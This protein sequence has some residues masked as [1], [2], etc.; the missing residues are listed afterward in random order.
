MKCFE[1]QAPNEDDPIIPVTA[2][3]RTKIKSDGTI[4]KLKARV[5]LRGDQ[6]AEMMDFETWCPVGNFRGLRIFLCFAA[7]LKCR[8]YQLDFV[9]AFLQAKAKNRVFTILPAEWKEF[10]PDLAEWFGTPLRL[11]KSIYGSTDSMRNWDDTLA[12]FL[13][14]DFGFQRCPSDGSIYIYK[15]GKSFLYLINAVDDELYFTN[16]E[17]LKAEFE[18]RITEKFDV[19]LMGQAHWYLQARLT[20]HANYSITLDQSRYMALIASRFLPQHPTTNITTEDKEKY[21]SPLPTTFV[22]SKEDCSKDSI[23]VKELEQKYGFQY[24]SA[25]GMLIFPT[26]HH[27]DSTVCHPKISKVQCT[28]WKAALQSSHPSYASCP[29]SQN[30]IW[31]T[32]PCPRSHTT[33]SSHC[34]TM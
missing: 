29:N 3:F 32:I 26:Q 10:Y 20:Q 34:E 23:E 4:E 19:K 11:L 9:G 30:R 22:P 28:T 31:L 21:R 17:Q 1:K 24:S 25:V 7:R 2:K 18:K 15:K 12:D 16:D 33:N 6:Q 8:I 27:R 14:N 13:L 5:C